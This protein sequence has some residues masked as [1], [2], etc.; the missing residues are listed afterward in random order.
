VEPGGEII[1]QMSE[2]SAAIKL[3]C[4]VYEAEVCWYDTGRWTQWVD[5]LA[6]VVEVQGKW[7]E[8][9]ST[10]VWES[11]PAGRGRVTERVTEYGPRSGQTT[12]VQDDSITARQTV[13][14][15]PE[16]DGVQV[17]LRLDYQLRQRTPLSA[18]ANWLFIRPAMTRSLARTLARFGAE[19]GERR[20]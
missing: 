4:S 6:R 16:N 15:A 9:G 14:F 8:P 3:P 10:V 18:L 19:L 13:A 5:Q 11:G 1:G 17:E 7:P 12:E 20:Q 2:V